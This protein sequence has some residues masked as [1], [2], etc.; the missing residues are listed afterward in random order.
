MTGNSRLESDCLLPD[1][2]MALG[3]GG[4]K[5]TGERRLM[6]AVLEDA[7]DRYRRFALARDPR[8]RAEYQGAR[9]WIDDDELEWLYS[10]ENICE[11]MGFDAAYLR[12]RLARAYPSRRLSIGREPQLVPLGDLPDFE[13]GVADI[14]EPREANVGE[15]DQVA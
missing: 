9:E 12:K 5:L 14:D 3:G 7:L 6:L 15:F 10:F 1:Q 2:Y 13:D 11:V 4:D 8:G